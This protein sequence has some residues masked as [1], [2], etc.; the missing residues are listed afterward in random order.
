MSVMLLTEHHLEFLSLTGGCI[1][2][3]ESTHVKIPHCWKS[4]VTAHIVT[5]CE[6]YDG[7]VPPDTNFFDGC[8]TCTCLGNGLLRCTKI[9]CSK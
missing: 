8:N 5:G 9:G 7:T 4:G 6:V 1:G 2:S 3:S